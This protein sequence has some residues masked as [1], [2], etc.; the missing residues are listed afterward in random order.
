[1][2]KSDWNHAVLSHIQPDLVEQAA[3]PVGKRATRSMR[4]A[5]IAACLCVIL[6]GTAFAVDEFYALFSR[7]FLSENGFTYEVSSTVTQYPM[8]SFS[9]ALLEASENRGTLAVVKREFATWEE[10]RAFIGPGV[11]LTWPNAES[12]QGGYHVYLFHTG[13]DKLWGIRVESLDLNAQASVSLK[14]YTEHRIDETV[15]HSTTS[16]EDTAERM[17]PYTTAAGFPAELVL[18]RGPEEHPSVQCVGSFTRMGV[19]YSAE[20][21]GTL[22]TQEETVLRLHTLLDSFG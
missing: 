9:D 17:E 10:V 18:I 1:M 7:L 3:D 19:I 6:V 16:T 14:I 2:N 15:V 5:V 13:G 21:Y 4:I 11:D 12:W 8:D 20:T 22:S